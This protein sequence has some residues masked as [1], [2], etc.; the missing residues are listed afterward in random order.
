MSCFTRTNTD[1]MVWT[2]ETRNLT[3]ALHIE[4]EDTDPSESFEDA[5]G[6]ESIRNGSVEWF[7]AHM[8]CYGP[9]GEVF[10]LPHGWRPDQSG[11]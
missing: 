5:E 1:T 8:A 9:N 11:Y 7:V 3:I 10:S 2:F 4:P 6:I